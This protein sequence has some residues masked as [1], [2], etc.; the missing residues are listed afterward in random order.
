MK[1]RMV[2]L[3][4]SLFV[5]AG[6]FA[7]DPTQEIPDAYSR[8]LLAGGCFWSMEAA[9]EKLDGVVD[10]VSGY[11]GGKSVD[12][13]YKTYNRGGHIEVIQVT[14]DPARISY[15]RLL[16]YYWRQINPTDA[17]GQFVDRGHAYIST[18]FYYD[19]EQR[20]AAEVSK[21]DLVS[22][23]RFNKPIVTPIEPAPV[24]YPAED[25]HQDFYKRGLEYEFY[26]SRSGRDRFLDKVWGKQRQRKF[27]AKSELKKSLTPLQYQV[28]QEDDTEPPFDNLY[29]DHKEAGI[30]VDI[31]SGEPLFSS[32]EKY[33]SGTG[34]PS[35]FRPLVEANVVRMDDSA[36]Y[37]E[38][39]SKQANSHLGHV[40]PDGPP[41]TGLRYCVN[42]AALRFV[43][44]AELEKE[45]YARF[46]GRFQ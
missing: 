36:V 3:F 7:A 42:S 15:P 16:D 32:R 1:K 40:F 30:Y 37:S 28:T 27:M 43:P 13:G 2:L 44:V 6:S 35:F 14:F 18:I 23:G 11:A 19:E 12:P 45:G 39:R 20:R 24:F 22:G 4:A 26:R 31:V 21:A 10:V 46:L 38:V 9:F 29:W 41:P 5:S 25:Q 17:G 8:A 34:W 33:D